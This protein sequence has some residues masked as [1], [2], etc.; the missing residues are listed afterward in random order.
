[1]KCVCIRRISRGLGVLVQV[2]ESGDPMD[3]PAACQIRGHERYAK[4]RIYFVIVTWWLI[5][6]MTSIGITIFLAD[7][8]AKCVKAQ[9]LDHKYFLKF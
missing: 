7:I 2:G 4:V 5:R 8:I 9:Y 3:S 6:R 1:M